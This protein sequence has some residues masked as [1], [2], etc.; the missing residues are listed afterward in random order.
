MFFTLIVGIY[1]PG[2]KINQ[3]SIKSK[4]KEV[5]RSFLVFIGF[6]SLKDHHIWHPTY[7]SLC[8]LL[9][10]NDF[11]ITNEIWQEGWDNKVL[12]LT[13]KKSRNV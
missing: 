1:L 7:T 10:D 6:K 5:L 8:K 4:L 12:Y 3:L 2:G 13:A 11:S 9:N